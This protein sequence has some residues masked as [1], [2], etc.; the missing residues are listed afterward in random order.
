MNE[1][2][3]ENEWKVI[4]GENDWNLRGF[5]KTDVVVFA[6]VVGCGR[7]QSHVIACNPV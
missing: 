6:P 1:R 7:L 2:M 4:E 3:N 5:L